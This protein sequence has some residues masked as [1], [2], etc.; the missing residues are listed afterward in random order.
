MK[1]TI[2]ASTWCQNLWDELILKNEIALF[3]EKYH[4]DDICFQIFSYDVDNIFFKKNNI[5]YLEYFPIDSKKISNLFR[6]FKNFVLFIKTIISSSVVVIGWG[7]LFY[8]NEAQSVSCPLKMWLF[9]SKLVKIF[10]KNLIFYAVSINIKHKQNLYLVKKLFSLW[11]EIFVRDE[12][13]ANTLKWLKIKS[14]L[15]LDPVF[16]D[17]KDNLNPL[18]K[19]FCFHKLNSKNF[20]LSDLKKINFFEKKVG[21]SFRKWYLSDKNMHEKNSKMAEKLEIWKF[22]E[23]IKYIFDAWAKKIIL[24]SHSFHK[25]DKLANDYD[26]Y[27]SLKRELEKSWNSTLL[28]KIKATENMH[29]TYSAYKSKKVDICLSQRLHSMILSQVYKIPFVWFSYSAKT[30]ELLKK[31]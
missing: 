11:D 19:S 2:L 30:D 1:I 10:R 22:I 13:S 21:V 3:K 12:F 7:G 9:R 15:I 20:K 14:N 4:K 27:L 26:F 23:L 25:T 28:K 16:Y 6:N 29:E 18:E 31:L 17:N 8:D 5:N 24:L